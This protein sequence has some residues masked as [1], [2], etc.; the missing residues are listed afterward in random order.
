MLYVPNGSKQSYESADVWRRFVIEEMPA[1]EGVETP[2]GSPSRG[3]KVLRDGLLLIERNG[4][5]YTTSG[6]ELR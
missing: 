2:S 3:E 6:A 5:T 1:Q 4:K